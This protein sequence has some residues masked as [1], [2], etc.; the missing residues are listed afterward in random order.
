MA[1]EVAEDTFVKLTKEEVGYL[2]AFY[3][4]TA[5]SNAAEAWKKKSVSI[6]S[7]KS[8]RILRS[9]KDSE[10]KSAKSEQNGKEGN[11]FKRLFEDFK[12]AKVSD[13]AYQQSNVRRNSS[14][15]P[16]WAT[17]VVQPI[18]KTEIEEPEL[19]SKT[20]EVVEHSTNAVTNRSIIF[21]KEVIGSPKV[22][23]S[24][25]KASRESTPRKRLST[26]DHHKEYRLRM[27][28]SYNGSKLFMPTG[29]QLFWVRRR[30]SFNISS[31]ILVVYF[32]S[33]FY[34]SLNPF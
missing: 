23:L 27:P 9:K 33:P 7:P 1:T 15:K 4:N 18:A 32:D 24:N 3:A 28:P 20:I 12:K 8:G 26:V 17:K 30:K 22:T 5:V 29:E 25:V 6:I 34:W 31:K 2:K 19:S 10:K 14:Y 21:A 16:F 13:Y 11:F